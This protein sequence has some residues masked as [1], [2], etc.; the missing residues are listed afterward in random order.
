MAQQINLYQAAFRPQ[1]WTFATLLP[2]GAAAGLILLLLF[3]VLMRW[4]TVPLRAELARLQQQ[5]ATSTQRAGELSKQ[6]TV[7]VK[8]TQLEQE[9]VRLQAEL[10]SK[11]KT[12]QASTTDVT[13]NIKGLSPYMEGLARQR[14]Q[15]LWLSGVTLGAGGTSIDI[16]GSTLAPELVPAYIQRLAGEAVFA[17]V[18][19][20]TLTMERVE[21]DGA[22]I[23]FTLRTGSEPPPAAAPAASPAP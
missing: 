23:D 5:Q 19:F 7:K 13:G 2:L 18:Q 21:T 10:E 20:R 14:P 6:F 3:Y 8:D 16:T 17:G 11:R 9:I 1:R 4:Q 22:H 15:G 12:V